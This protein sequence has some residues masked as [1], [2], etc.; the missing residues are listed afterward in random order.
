MSADPPRTPQQRFEVEMSPEVEVGVHADFANLWHTPDTIVLD[1]A[2]LR[3]P[4]YIQVEDTGT[5][6]AIA[7]TRIV[8]R[9]R[10]PPRQVWELMRA[11]E[12]EL[13]AWEHETGQTLPPPSG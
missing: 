10:L 5:E 1:F 13:T 9:L 11:L 2:A 4:P 3:Q 12:K 8:A 6:V 7:P